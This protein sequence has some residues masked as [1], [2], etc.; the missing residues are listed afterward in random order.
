MSRVQRATHQSCHVDP[1]RHPYEERIVGY[2]VA[3]AMAFLGMVFVNFWVLMDNTISCPDWLV[4]FL[5]L[6]QGRA[7]ATFVVLAGA[8]LTLLSK[9]LYHHHNMPAIRANRK[10]IWR[11]AFVLFVIGVLNTM[12]WPADILHFYAFYFAAGAV[13]VTA[14]NQRLAALTLTSVL[15]FSLFMVMTDFDPGW[16]WGALSLKEW[17]NLPKVARHLLFSGHYPFF[18]WISFL[19]IGVWLGRQDLSNIRLRRTLLLVATGGIVLSEFLSWLVFDAAPANV[20]GLDMEPVL[21][22]FATDPWEPMP[23]FVI[24]A[25]GTAIIVILSFAACAQQFRDTRWLQPLIAVGQ[26]TLSL[27]V[28]HIVVAETGLKLLKFWNIDAGLFPLW[29]GLLYFAM[30]LLSASF[31]NRH[32]HRGPLEWM[33]RR[34]LEARMVSRSVLFTYGRTGNVR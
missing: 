32:F 15:V 25:G 12:I 29:G 27:Y 20:F 28:A 21:P 23:L 5:E 1:K 24:S 6:I 7:A 13:L 30:A 22:W 31:W 14:S 9:N 19:I 16:E 34:L 4:F 11:R 18:P 2:D 17:L 10:R 3:R 33:M 26:S 8:G